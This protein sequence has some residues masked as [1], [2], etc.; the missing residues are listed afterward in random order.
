LG[1]GWRLGGC[2]LGVDAG[3]HGNAE[4]TIDG[5]VLAAPVGGSGRCRRDGGRG[6][7]AGSCWRFGAVA[8]EAIAEQAHEREPG[9]E[10]EQPV[11]CGDD[12]RAIGFS[13]GGLRWWGDWRFPEG[14]G[15]GH[16]HGLFYRKIRTSARCFYYI[17]KIF[18]VETCALGVT[19]RRVV[20][21]GGAGAVIG[22]ELRGHQAQGGE[23]AGG[24]TDVA[25]VDFHAELTRAAAIYTIVQTAKLDS[26][27][28]EAYLCDT[29]AKIAVG[30]PISRIT[31]LLPWQVGAAERQ[32]SI[33]RATSPSAISRMLSKQCQRIAVPAAD[34]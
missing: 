12:G 20:V 6:V 27:N 4:L 34:H 33:K 25:D 15:A 26:V 9:G 18:C 17:R 23:A 30:H 8:G 24:I 7:C 14:C 31:E 11:E 29:L 2:E 10:N 32:Q 22:I 1:D 13:R 3:E 16:F 5:A 28:P 19:R 21:G